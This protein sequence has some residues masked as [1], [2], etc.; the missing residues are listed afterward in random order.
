MKLVGPSESAK[1]HSVLKALED[2]ERF[3]RVLTEE[4]R[5]R[6]ASYDAKLARAGSGKIGKDMRMVMSM[7]PLDFFALVDKYGYEEV[8]SK[9][10][11]R[12]NQKAHPEQRVHKV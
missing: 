10:F 4:K 7:D 1:L 11:I 3:R 8:H 9:E 5:H 6:A 12:Y 2:G